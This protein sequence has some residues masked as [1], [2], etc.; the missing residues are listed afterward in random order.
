MVNI[1]IKSR[2]QSAI[3][4]STIGFISLLIPLLLQFYYRKVLDLFIQGYYEEGLLKLN[5]LVSIISGDLFR[6]L[7]K[8]DKGSQIRFM[9]EYEICHPLN[10]AII[11][12]SSYL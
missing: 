5:S 10:V 6:Q 2:K 7:A 4:N 1:N 12:G 3:I 8:A 9:G 11:S